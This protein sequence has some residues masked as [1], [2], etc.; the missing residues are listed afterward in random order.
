MLRSG[1]ECWFLHALL[2]FA[3][4]SIAQASE[5]EPANKNDV[6]AAIGKD[7]Q[8]E[9]DAGRLTG[10][11]VA[12]V[13]D[14]RIVW[15]D[16]FGWADR[17]AGTRATSATAFSVASTTKPFTTT[18][19]MTLVRDGKLDF[20]RPA[21]DYLGAEKI[22]DQDGPAQSAT[23]RHLAT[24]SSGLPTFFIMYPEGGAARQPP[25]A[26]LIRDYGHLVAPVGERYEYS[27]LAMGILGEIVAR[28]SGQTLGDYLQAQVLTPLGMKDSFFDTDLSR[29]A[30][31][32]VRHADDGKPLPFYLTA[33]PGSGELYASARDLARFAMLHLKD[34]LDASA[35]ILG[36]AQLDELHRPA[37]VV[38][39]G[40]SYAMGW[41]V[42]RRAGE[43]EVLY[44]GG[45][46]SGVE[47]EFVLLPGEDVAAIVLSNRRSQNDFIEKLRDRMIRTV[48]PEWHGIPSP[49][50]A[51]LLPLD[52]LADYAGE[53]RG[54][55]LAQGRHVPVVLTIT[56]QGQGSL[57]LHGRAAQ[58]IDKLGLV[59]GL[60]SGDI[61]GQVGSPDE[62]RENLDDL[63][64]NLKLRGDRIDGEIV[65]WRKT[66][67]N[68]TFLPFWT[69][70][71]RSGP[72]Q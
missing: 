26:E 33:T 18:A 70:L 11:A 23:V 37:T 17:T 49:P 5:A 57:S 20:D 71:E 22:V 53:W 15:Q 39:P 7:I 47:T 32:A 46:Q 40:Y 66:S 34:D 1:L 2:V 16:G 27:N 61:K 50:N 30:E 64:L 31:M 35:R 28:Q 9:I 19:L 48:V 12:L 69:A 54:T 8:A 68:M 62:L 72:K 63:A 60:I 13:K 44:H 41:Q 29:R 59:D 65:A 6:Y 55:V 43:P 38:A 25:M 3:G 52:P 21:N 10:V 58:P 42:L 45:G 14:G 51:S 56:P 36:D 4:T 24:H 67:E